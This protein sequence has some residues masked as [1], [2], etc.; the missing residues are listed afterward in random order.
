MEGK[1]PDNKLLWQY[2][3]LTTQILFSVGLTLWLG[4]WLDQ[5]IGW[6]RE[7]LVWVLPLLALL[8]IFYKIIR[9]TSKKQ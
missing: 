4:K 9:D 5:Q 2:A 8:G 1:Q 6:G 3:G 7:L